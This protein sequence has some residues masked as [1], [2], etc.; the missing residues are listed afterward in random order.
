M[1]TAPPFKVNIKSLRLAINALRR[2]ELDFL[3]PKTRRNDK[4]SAKSFLFGLRGSPMPLVCEVLGINVLA[5]RLLILQWKAQGKVGDPV[6]NYLTD[7]KNLV[8]VENG[9]P[10]LK[11]D[12]GSVYAGINS[13]G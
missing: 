5:G 13:C 2:A 12:F 7:P 6:F 9:L 10:I 3:D 8:R 4:E 11:P 1:E